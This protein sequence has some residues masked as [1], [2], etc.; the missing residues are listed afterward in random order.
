MERWCEEMVQRQTVYEFWATAQRLVT[1]RRRGEDVER[2]LAR[3]EKE[4][5]RYFEMASTRLF[6]SAIYRSRAEAYLDLT[7]HYI[8]WLRHLLEIAPPTT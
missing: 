4:I 1:R 5:C 6:H 8:P 2:H 3:T 7:E